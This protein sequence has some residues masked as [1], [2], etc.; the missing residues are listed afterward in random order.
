MPPNAEVFSEIIV[1]LMLK[2]SD[3]SFDFS[4]LILRDDTFI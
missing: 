1:V 4:S 3:R 2:C